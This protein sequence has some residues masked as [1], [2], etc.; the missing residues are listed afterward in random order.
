MEAID[1][2][3][4]DVCEEVGRSRADVR[5]LPVTKTVPADILRDAFEAGMHDFAENKVQEAQGKVVL[6]DDLP[7][8]WIMVG[9]L[10][11]NKVKQMVQFATEFH[12]LDSL[13]FVEALDRQLARTNRTL[14]V[15]VQANTSGEVSK[16]G[17]ES[18][19]VADFITELAAFEHLRPRGLMTLAV[20]SASCDRVRACS[21]VLRDLR[22]RA[23]QQNPEICELSIGM[24][25]D[26]EDAIREGAIVV[27]IGQA[28]FG[29]RPTPDAYYWLDAVPHGHES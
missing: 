10:Q 13:R 11:T 20:F 23:L 29:E 1:R 17:L 6:L 8:R 7:I 9:H 21:R 14:D 27:W 24:S 15:F 26:Y 16:Y 2:R 4:A 19:A 28:I 3:I 5:L 12:A 25:G 18:D 22:D